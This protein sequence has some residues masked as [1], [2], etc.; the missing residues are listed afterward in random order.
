MAFVKNMY[1][2]TKNAPKSADGAKPSLAQG[3]MNAGRALAGQEMDQ[4]VPAKATNKAKM[5]VP[6]EPVAPVA[7]AP[8]VAPPVVPGAP[9]PPAPIP[10]PAGQPMGK[11]VPMRNVGPAKKASAQ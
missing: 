1:Q 3:V 5:D 7:G 8:A 9:V 6:Q 4:A 10:Q 2:Q 11:A